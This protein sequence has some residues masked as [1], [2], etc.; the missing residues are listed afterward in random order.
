MP[1]CKDRGPDAVIQGLMPTLIGFLAVF[2]LLFSGVPIAIGMAVVGFAGFAI[3]INT[4]AA[5]SMVGQTV[6]ENAANYEYAVLPLFVLM[7]NY[8]ARSGLSDDLYKMSRAFL[9][10]FRGGLAMATILACGGFSAVCGSSLATAATMSKVAMPPMRQYGY[11][12]S[13]ATGSIAAGGTLGILIPPSTIMVIYGIMTNVDIG[14]LMIA[15]IVP[16]II[17]VAMYILTIAVVTRIRPALGPAAQAATWS[18]RFASLKDIWGVLA[19]FLLVMGVI[20]LG[21]CTPTEA[22]G[23]GAAGS[24]FFALLRRN[25]RFSDHVAVLTETGRTTAMMFVVLFGAMIFNNFINVARMPQAVAAWVQGLGL[26]PLL[27]LLVIVVVYLILGCILESFSMILLTVPIFYPVVSALGFDMIWFGI[28]IVI[29]TEISLISPPVG[30]NVFVMR[31]VLPE[32]RVATIFRGVM[33]FLVADA[34][35]LSLFILVPAIVMFLPRL[36]R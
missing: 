11:A 9:G 36:M 34:L 32:V 7:G 17:T 16:G 31:A 12:D 33:P 13:L 4:N 1:G 25:M 22:A 14:K 8:V 3:L 6:Y 10:H 23:I 20:Y 26:S 19:L 5:F 24:F 21:V 27:V 2:V 15:G 28:I 35:R 29:V 30:M 18:E